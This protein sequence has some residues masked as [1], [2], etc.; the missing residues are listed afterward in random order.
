MN[1]NKVGYNPLQTRQQVGFGMSTLKLTTYAS[2]YVVL[3]KDAKA[4]K[5][6]A[7]K[8]EGDGKSFNVIVDYDGGAKMLYAKIFAPA[9]DHVC[10]IDPKNKDGKKITG[11]DNISEIIKNILKQAKPQIKAEDNRLNAQDII[12]DLI[13]K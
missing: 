10:I 2:K 6:M 8:L 9:G 12:E 1:I 3:P 4:I 5:A 13:V 7:E 11:T